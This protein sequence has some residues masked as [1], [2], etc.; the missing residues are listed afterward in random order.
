MLEANA[1]PKD[2]EFERILAR[3]EG[4]TV[5]PVLWCHY[6]EKDNHSDETCWSTRPL[7]WKPE[8]TRLCVCSN[9]PQALKILG[10]KCGSCGGLGWK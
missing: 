5:K 3:A 4:K 2:P 6:C 9:A 7:N 1:I 8:N 10:I